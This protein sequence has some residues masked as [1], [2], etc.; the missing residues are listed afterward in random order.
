MFSEP[1]VVIETGLRSAGFLS[2]G[3]K[4]TL[5]T[6]VCVRIKQM[7]KRCRLEVHPCGRE[8]HASSE[9]APY[10]PVSSCPATCFL[11]PGD[12]EPPSS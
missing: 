11:P 2:K 4:N 7:N 12:L 6:Y 5:L 1:K 9:L 10:F 3:P 8:N